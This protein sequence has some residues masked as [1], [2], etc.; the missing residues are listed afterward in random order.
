MEIENNKSV[1]DDII[2]I[3]KESIKFALVGIALFLAIGTSL[4]YLFIKFT[5]IDMEI[6]AMFVGFVAAIVIIIVDDRKIHTVDKIAECNKR[7]VMKFL[8]LR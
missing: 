1:K 3:V 8:K 6:A 7:I 2:T 4:L 5:E